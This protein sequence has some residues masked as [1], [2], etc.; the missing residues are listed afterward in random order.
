MKL[1]DLK[2]QHQA[3]LTDAR[4][5]AAKGN[6]ESYNSYMMSAARVEHEITAIEKQ[7]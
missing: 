1:F 2:Q 6:T 4:A 7:P 5:A 3:L